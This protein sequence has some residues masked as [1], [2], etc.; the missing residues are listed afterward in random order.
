M[1]KPTEYEIAKIQG[2]LADIKAG[3]VVS[4]EDSYA[5]ARKTLRVAFKEKT[6]QKG[7]VYAGEVRH[8]AVVVS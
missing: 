4:W 5:Q 6:Q 8:P 1:Y 2:G 3:R 7:G